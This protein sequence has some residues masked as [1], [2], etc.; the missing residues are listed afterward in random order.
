MELDDFDLALIGQTIDSETEMPVPLSEGGEEEIDLRGVLQID[1]TV[2]MDG[3]ER[4]IRNNLWDELIL[5]HR[6]NPDEIGLAMDEAPARFDYWKTLAGLARRDLELYELFFET[7]MAGVAA[8]AR[9][10]LHAESGKAS[11][12][13]TDR[14]VR[15]RV[16]VSHPQEFQGYQQHLIELRERLNRYEAAA[17]AWDKRCMTLP[18]V[19]KLLVQLLELDGS[20]RVYA[21][22]RGDLRVERFG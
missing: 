9:V 4:K 22:K 18:S 13:F 12:T 5:A 3:R 10:Q 8:K 14:A 7:W 16:I 6:E 11:G 2:Q 19:A 17:R 15:D 1:D 20:L 21:T